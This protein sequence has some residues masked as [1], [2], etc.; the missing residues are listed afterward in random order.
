MSRR[1]LERAGQTQTSHC[2]GRG[3]GERMGLLL[4][5]TIAT[6]PQHMDV[7]TVKCQLSEQ[8]GTGRRS[9]N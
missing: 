5:M 8:V 2:T 7:S 4:C 1:T 3:G 6:K 9:D